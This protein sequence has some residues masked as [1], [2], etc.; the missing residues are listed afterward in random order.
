MHWILHKYIIL[1]SIDTKLK[2]KKYEE[3]AE[4]QAV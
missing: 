3:G 2:K 1:F 4:L